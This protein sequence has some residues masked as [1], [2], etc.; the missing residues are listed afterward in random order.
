MIAFARLIKTTPETMEQAMTLFIQFVEE[1]H[2]NDVTRQ[3]DEYAGLLL[4]ISSGTWAFPLEFQTW[5]AERRL[6]STSDV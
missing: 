5:R 4:E 1:R 2:A 6:P 3:A